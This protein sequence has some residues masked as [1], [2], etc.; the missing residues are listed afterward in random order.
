[1]YNEDTQGT[2]FNIQKFSLH[3]GP[4]I[5]TIVFLKGCYLSCKWCSNPESQ[6]FKPS[7]MFEKEK[8]IGCGNCAKTCPQEAISLNRPNR[9]DHDKCIGCGSCVGV[10]PSNA[11]TL[12]GSKM[13][14][15]EVL[16]EVCKDSVHYRRSNGGL[17]LSGGEPL[18]QPEFV[19]ELLRAA[20][21]RGLHTAME[22]TGIA[23]PDVL[24]RI[25]PLLDVV[26]LDIKTFYSKQHEKYTGL[27]NEVVL[28]NALTISKL[29]KQV[30][31]R[32]PL[33]P[34]FNADEQSVKAIATFA[35]HMDNVARLHLLPYHN[36]GQ[37][38]Y[39]LLGKEYYCKEFKTPS[40]D[41]VNRYKEIVESL[42]IECVVGG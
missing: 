30:S 18:A 21:A 38:K 16:D 27:A 35:T 19:E 13:S 37:N 11:L 14:V 17:T 12:A 28:K 33:I 24:K 40:N 20:K 8:C 42:G 36:F 9:V 23:S 26:L 29:A 32:V 10:C 6:K 4:G 2:V 39:S 7:V 34:E 25:I 22:T 1:M 31:I 41:E 5:R 3:D 15:K